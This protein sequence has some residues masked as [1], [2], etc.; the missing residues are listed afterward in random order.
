M[1]EKIKVVMIYDQRD[2]SEALR[3]IL[4]RLDLEILHIYSCHEAAGLF[5]QADSAELVF[6]DTTLPDG[7][8]EDVLR[9]ARQANVFLPVIVVSRAIDIDLYFKALESGAFDFVTPPFLTD[10]LA[11]VTG[12]AMYQKLVS[13]DLQPM[14]VA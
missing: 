13:R 3:K 11:N 5:K 2:P 7:T 4:K 10:D 12:S 6:T 8:W 1:G 9:L 14:Y